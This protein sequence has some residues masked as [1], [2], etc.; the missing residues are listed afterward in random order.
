MKPR[1][2]V[3]NILR[4]NCTVIEAEATVDTIRYVFQ[5]FPNEFLPVVEGIRFIGVVF[6]DE[7]LA[8]YVMGLDARLM[9]KELV[10]KEMV[11]LSPENTME[12]AREIFDTK[13]YNIIPVVDE[14]KDLMGIILRE[15][16]E[17]WDKQKAGFN[18][19]GTLKRF[20]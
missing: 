10:S 19:F 6:R 20:F 16:F 12:H 18:P 7:F 15:D 9:A 13:T 11:E 14:H 4:T 1:N 17:A 5:H 3:T 8:Q 2:S